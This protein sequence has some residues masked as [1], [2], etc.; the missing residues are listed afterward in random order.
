MPRSGCAWSESQL[1][2]QIFQ[3]Q[4]LIAFKFLPQNEGI[5]V[6]VTLILN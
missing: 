2:K 3:V 1:K 5:F 6:K 4:T